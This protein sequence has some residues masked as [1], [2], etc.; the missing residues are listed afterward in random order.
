MIEDPFTAPPV[1]PGTADIDAAEDAAR[2]L[3]EAMIM[4]PDDLLGDVGPLAQLLYLERL[5]WHVLTGWTG[6]L[7]V[8]DSG[9]V[10]DDSEPVRALAALGL[11]AGQI[12]AACV[13][14][15]LLPPE[16]TDAPS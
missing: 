13:L 6:M 11:A 3:A 10:P 9:D 5:A 7:T 8:A 15:A 14:V 2:E 12:D 16:A 1:D 4:P